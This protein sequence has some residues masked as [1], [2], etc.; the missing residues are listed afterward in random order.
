MSRWRLIAVV[1]TALM[2]MP[3]VARAD[4]YPT[5][6]ITILV[7]FAPGGGTDLLARA[8]AGILQKQ[9]GQSFIIENR[10]GGGTTLA[11]T[12]TANAKPDGYTLMQGTSGTMSMDP[13]IFKHLNYEPLKTLVPVALIAGVPFVLTVNPSL[14]VHSV[15]D[16]VALA[17]KRAAEG[18]PLTYGSGG[19]G[20]FHHL[21]A[22]LFSS[23]TGITMTH[24]PYRGSAPAT[25]ALI[26]G[27]V[28]VLFV[29][30][31][32]MLPQI[33]AGKAR[34]LGITSDKPFP[35]APD[36]KPLSQVGLPSWPDTVAW[37]MLLAPG[38]TPQPIL[39]KLN[40]DVNA[41]VHAPAMN[42]PL[43]KLG[44]IALGDKSLP[45]LD[46]YVKSESVRWS[47]V[48]KDANLAGTQ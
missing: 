47:K 23:L 17:K 28:D 9:Y 48:I 7:P 6:N 20:A 26:S 32:P 16:L 13:T 24:V 3:V 21:C 40:K 1:L 38:G 39:E 30:L 22:A 33:R 44:M 43:E 4:D 18:K 45:Q 2:A 37:Q 41:A 14:P 36:I 5:R 34:V 35:T 12:V 8:Y 10:P 42:T 19:V 27:Q 31:G 25:L 46:A 29:D 15:A 11:A